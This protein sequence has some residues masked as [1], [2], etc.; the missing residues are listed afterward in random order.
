MTAI[1]VELSDQALEQL[2]QRVAEILD[3]RDG[4]ERWLRVEEAAK[5][6]GHSVEHTRRLGRTGAIETSK[7]G[8]Y[9]LFLE[10]SLADYKAGER[11][12]RAR[13]AQPQTRGRRRP[14]GSG[15]R[16]RF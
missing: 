11:R 16:T 4:E 7:P 10:S 6:L 13:R 1:A 2:A 14:A 5:L 8:K 9:V 12:P 3:H 15:K